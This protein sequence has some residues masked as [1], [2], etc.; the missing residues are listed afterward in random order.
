MCKDGG[1]WCRLKTA[2]GLTCCIGLEKQ[3]EKT[4]SFITFVNVLGIAI[5]IG[6]LWTWEES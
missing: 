1:S 5:G 4:I 6:P 3:R 2:L